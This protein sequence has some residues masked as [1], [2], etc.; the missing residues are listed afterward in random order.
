MVDRREQRHRRQ[1]DR[2]PL[3]ARLDLRPQRPPRGQRIAREAK[4]RFGTRHLAGLRAVGQHGDSPR[5]TGRTILD[6]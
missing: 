2:R 4:R 5:V 6:E 3:A 1:V